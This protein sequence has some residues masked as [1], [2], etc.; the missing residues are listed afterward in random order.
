MR[1]SPLHLIA[2]PL[3]QIHSLVHCSICTNWLSNWSLTNLRRIYPILHCFS[4]CNI[5][6]IGIDRCPDS[7]PEKMGPQGIWR[8]WKLW[9]SLHIHCSDD[10]R[11]CGALFSLQ[12][13]LFDTIH[14]KLT[15]DRYV[16]PLTGY[17]SGQFTI[18][19]CR[20]AVFLEIWFSNLIDHRS[21]I[22]HI[23][24][25]TRARVEFGSNW[26]CI[27]WGNS[28]HECFYGVVIQTYWGSR[29][30]G[31]T[32][33]DQANRY[34]CESKGQLVILFSNI[35]AILLSYSRSCLF[36]EE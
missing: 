36:V 23:P 31:L 12:P 15:F 17:G 8:N 33:E 11:V 20:S 18:C 28:V 32:T 19:G 1:N 35:L 10:H 14:H 4:D 34:F 24:S 29:A 5:L 26:S 7:S 2:D 13:I 22:D 3:Y 21:S 16:S 6:H 25:G 9:K 30:K 27:F